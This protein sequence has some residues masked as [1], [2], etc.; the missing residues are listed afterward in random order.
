MTCNKGEAEI[1]KRGG[2]TPRKSI[3][4]EGEFPRDIAPPPPD[5]TA[6]RISW[7]TCL[8]TGRETGRGNRD[9]DKNDRDNGL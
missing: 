7:D 1:P 6:G 9:R 8:Q 3:P 2:D 5:I 4:F